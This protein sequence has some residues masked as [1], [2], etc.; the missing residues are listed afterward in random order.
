[1]Q[2]E[3]GILLSLPDAAQVRAELVEHVQ[4]EFALRKLLEAAEAAEEY[5]AQRQRAD[6]RREGK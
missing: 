5:R 3:D 4:A 1:M 2:P 6:Q